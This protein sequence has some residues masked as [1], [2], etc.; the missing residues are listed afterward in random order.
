M[1]CVDLH[2]LLLK[3][4][5]SPVIFTTPLWN[6]NIPNL[7]Y[8]ANGQVINFNNVGGVAKRSPCVE[9]IP[10]FLENAQMT[11]TFRSIF[12]IEDK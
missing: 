5:G 2:E 11:I 8:F 12:N 9:M 4:H 3:Q 6:V 1:V 7:Y 10:D